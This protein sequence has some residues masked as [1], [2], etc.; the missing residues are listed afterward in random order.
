LALLLALGACAPAPPGPVAR[1]GAAVV[2]TGPGRPLDAEELRGEEVYRRENCARCHTLFETAPPAGA[3][4]LPAPSVPA[5]LDSRVGPDLGLEGHRRSDDWQHA[6]LYAPDVVVPGSRMTAARHLYR[7]GGDGRPEPTED[8]TALV[9]WLQTLGRDARDV[10]AEARLAEPAIAAPEARPD[11]ERLALG[12]RLYERHCTPCHGASGDGRGPAAALFARPPRDFTLGAYRFRSTPAGSA[13]AAADL[14]RAI[15]LGSGTGAA[16]PGF[17]HLD[18]EERWALVRRILEFA[19]G[20]AGTALGGPAGATCAPAPVAGPRAEVPGGDP[21][22]AGAALY[23]ELGCA[24]CHGPGA[25][26]RPAP[27]NGT[28][29]QDESGRPIPGTGDLRHPCSRRG[30]A[31]EAALARALG[32]GVGPVM[33]SY[34]LAL[35][36]RPWAP[37]AIEAWLESPD[38][39]AGT[40]PGAEPAQ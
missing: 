24:A 21:V 32:C 38:T 23:A 31:S 3:F 18:A 36:G 13:P 17:G 14:F 30:G 7:P 6:H 37:R 22:A 35:E 20:A 34:A 9:A 40:R 25:H 2:R 39:G 5:A 19:P 8:A 26:G 4:V 10:W 12:T 29:W 11:G 15:T 16:M 1:N 33:P 28:A 27:E